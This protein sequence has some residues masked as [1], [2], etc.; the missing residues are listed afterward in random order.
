MKK[1][2]IIA[3]A[4][5]SLGSCE[6]FLDVQPEGKYTE[7]QF[8]QNDENS[9]SAVNSLY[10]LLHEESVFGRDIL[11]EQGAASTIAWGRT[12]GFNT[13]AQRNYTGDES[14]LNT[15]YNKLST[16]ISR[17]NWIVDGLLDK[18]LSVDLSEV[19]RR[20]LGEAY[21]MRGFAHF[22]LAYRY[23]TDQ[24]GVPFIRYEDFEGGYDNSIPTQQT[25]VEDNYQYIIDDMDAAIEYLPRFED[26]SAED[27]G[28]A[29]QAAAV[30]Y[31]AK[32]YAYWATWNSAKWDDVIT[33]VDLLEASY[34]R[35]LTTSLDNFFSCEFEDFWPNEYLWSIPSNGGT[36]NPGGCDI[37]VVM[38]ENK[39]WGKHNGWGQI[40]PTLDIYEE[41]AKDNV[42]GV[43]NDRLVRSILEYNDE[44]YYFGEKK[45]FYANEDVETGF[46]VN[47]Y[48]EPLKY[49]DPIAKGYL[50]TWTFTRLNFPLVRFAEMLL[51]RAEANI[52]KGNAGAALEDLNRIRRRS[53]LAELTAAPTMAELYH[54][55]RCELAF[56][57]TDHYADL[58]RWHKSGDA[59]IKAL[60]ASEL[61][62]HP[63]ARHYENRMDPLSTYVVGEYEDYKGRKPYEDYM[64]VFPYPSNE[65]TK[66]G[67]MLEQNFGY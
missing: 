31:K 11:W 22:F 33:M 43:K 66:A 2:F 32:V 44:F 27:Q 4:L 59:T 12:R 16:Y 67:G 5:L 41:M 34:G 65:I 48:M 28:R 45:S 10:H 8:F 3:L 58:K 54:E 42:G 18:S 38:L 63:R 49:A 24:Q 40:K 25:S 39:G 60:A 29:H 23:G 62:N 53:N 17:A 1:Y 37:G 19:E 51:F 30:A 57:F 14:P 20:S 46:Q 64:I 56:E 47:K 21:F 52:V 55:R 7:N 13:L 35:G 50:S 6:K 26:Y 9:I 15:I 61:N 36:T